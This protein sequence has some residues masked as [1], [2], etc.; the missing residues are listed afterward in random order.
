MAFLKS[1]RLILEITLISFKYTYIYYLKND[2]IPNR[3]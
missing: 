3:F 2:I 1:K